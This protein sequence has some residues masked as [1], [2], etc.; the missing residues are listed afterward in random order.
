M[1]E[2]LGRLHALAC[3][4]SASTFKEPTLRSKAYANAALIEFVKLQREQPEILTTLLKGGNQSAKRLNTDPY[5]GLREVIQNADDLNA[6][7][8]QFGV[9]TFNGS[10][11]LVIVHNGL[12]VELPHVLPMIYPFYSTKQQSAELKG[13]FGI[14]LKTLTQL[15]DN[16]TVHSAPFHFGSRDDRVAMVEEAE[17]IRD[18]YDPL[19]DH[20]MVSVDLY[21]DYDLASL[22]AWFDDWAPSDLIFLENVRAITLVDLDEGISLKHLVIQLTQS[23]R[24]FKLALGKH[25]SRVT[26]S[27]FWVDDSLWERFVCEVRVPAGKAR[28]DKATGDFTPIGVA[29]PV[30]GGARGR[31]HVA[32]PTK[33][34]TNAAFSLDAQFDPSTSREDMIHGAWNQW[35]T[36]AS[37]QFLGELAIYLAQQRNT[38]AWLAV[39]VGAKTNSSSDWLNKLFHEQWSKAIEAFKACPTLVDGRYAL[40]EISYCNESIDGMLTEAD[41]LTVSGWPMLPEWM[42]DSDGS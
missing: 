8:V 41:H 13:R 26:H 23:D 21:P 20:T 3:F 30:N 39:P 17:P 2:Q 1:D 7:S 27:T 29:V 10:K 25:Q 11:Q 35:L 4:N 5:Q 33:I 15:G 24:Q 9:K 34:H 42:R 40:S 18:F 38:L 19:A 36:E 31:I 14:G 16:L 22:E 28:A 12:P 6:T 37:G 32:L